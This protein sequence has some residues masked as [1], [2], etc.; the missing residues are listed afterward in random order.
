M[1]DRLMRFLAF[2]AV[3][4]VTLAILVTYVV[5]RASWAAGLGP[6]GR[7]VAMMSAWALTLTPFLARL[8]GVT[9]RDGVTGSLLAQIGFTAALTVVIGA[10][11]IAPFDVTRG[12]LARVGRWWQRRN[13]PVA[14]AAELAT[15]PVLPDPPDEPP[16]EEPPRLTRREVLARSYVAGAI[17]MGAST[18]VYG[19]ALGRRDYVIEQVPIPLRR[20]PRALDGYTI[21]QL[22]DVHVGTFVGER[23]LAAAVD[24]VRSARP[25]LVV[26][27][28]DLVDHDP[29]YAEQLGR[30]ARRLEQLG[31][32]DGVVAIP[33]NHDYYA[34]I[35]DVLGALRRAGTRVLRNQSMVIGDRGGAFALLGVDDVWASRSGEGPGADLDAALAEAPPD[36]ARVLLCHNPEYYPEAASRVDLQISGH[37][38]GGQVN[39]LVRPAHLV[40]PHG[41]IAGH[42]FR[43]ESQIYVNRGFGTAGPPARVGAPPEVSRIVLTSA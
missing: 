9:A 1:L 34:G 13:Q 10:G 6:R 37:T 32:R 4:A 42:Y 26:M 8:A 3:I 40:L 2:F 17:G 19:I 24:L 25:D 38:H 5:R 22:S 29:R 27:T 14:T 30:F 35:D 39:F 7:R 15:A 16:P 28:G 33:G 43:G 36:L 20:L 21:V 11:F 31:A 41:Y 23:E 12:L 18:A